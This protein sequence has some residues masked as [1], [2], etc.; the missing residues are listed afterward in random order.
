MTDHLVSLPLTRDTLEVVCD[1]VRLH[2]H[3]A[4]YLPDLHGASTAIRADTDTQSRVDLPTDPLGERG[5]VVLRLRGDAVVTGGT[6]VATPDWTEVTRVVARV[7]A[8][9]RTTRDG[10]TRSRP[11]RDDEAQA[12][13]TELLLRHGWEVLDIAVSAARPF[14]GARPVSGRRG[15]TPGPPNP[16]RRDEPLPAHFRVR[17][18][19]ASVQPVDPDL[20]RASL[21][22][23]IGRG[24]S[25]GLGMLV[26]LP[27]PPTD[28]K[29]RS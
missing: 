27:S 21:A 6:S 15:R 25:Y 4:E 2:K 23:G 5:H 3:V 1:P 22:R 17:D 8:E 18:L 24:R 28:T 9:K 19:T 13:A 12:W 14:A 7:A 20:A 29:E 26:P 16:V 10:V 11:V